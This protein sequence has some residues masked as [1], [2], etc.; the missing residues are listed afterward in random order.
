MSDMRIVNI[1]RRKQFYFLVVFWF[2]F[3]VEIGSCDCDNNG[4]V[5]ANVG[6][7]V[8][9]ILRPAVCAQSILQRG[10]AQQHAR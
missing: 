5:D 1:L 9:Q 10:G 4:T 8:P 6:A 2:A 7:A 3:F